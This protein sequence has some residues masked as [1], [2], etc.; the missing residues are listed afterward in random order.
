MSSSGLCVENYIDPEPKPICIRKLTTLDWMSLNNIKQVSGGRDLRLIYTN[1]L[2]S[3]LDLSVS[4][5]KFGSII[6]LS[7]CS[8]YD[9]VAHRPTWTPCEII[10]QAGLMTCRDSLC[11][12]VLYVCQMLDDRYA[13]VMQFSAAFI[14]MHLLLFCAHSATY[15]ICIRTR[16]C[17]R[18]D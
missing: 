13:F 2:A 10:K 6:P 4:F 12:Y 17:N 15:M 11:A 5:A 16:G 1:K 9:Q 7:K 18:Y 3:D 14:I 8:A